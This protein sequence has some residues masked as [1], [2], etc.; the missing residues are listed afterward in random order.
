MPKLVGRARTRADQTHISSE[1]VEQLRQFVESKG[2]QN[3][4]ARDDTRIPCSI[5]FRHRSI[6]LHKLLEVFL[7]GLGFHVHFHGSELE[8]Q[9]TRTS[10]ADALLPEENRSGRDNFDPDG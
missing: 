4:S 3:S 2:S 1:H 8:E 7:V 10:V 5:K 9:E 6:T